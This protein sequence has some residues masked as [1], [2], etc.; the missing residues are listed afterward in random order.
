MGS[1]YLAR[2]TDLCSDIAGKLGAPTPRDEGAYNP[3]PPLGRDD[4]NRQDFRNNDASSRRPKVLRNGSSQA[5]SAPD[6]QWMTNEG[7]VEGCDFATFVRELDALRLRMMGSSF[8][9]RVEAI[10]RQIAVDDGCGAPPHSL[11]DVDDGSAQRSIQD[12][13]TSAVLLLDHGGGTVRLR[14]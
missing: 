4:K 14:R 10:S 13:V 1:T 9:E 2:I 3:S 6:A 11:R 7:A 8:Y 12:A 5:Q